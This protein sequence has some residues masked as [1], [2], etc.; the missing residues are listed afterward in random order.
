[1]CLD[2]SKFILKR[3]QMYSIKSINSIM[4]YY[5]QID[6]KISKV[7]LA[8]IIKT[9]QNAKSKNTKF[10]ILKQFFFF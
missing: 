4:I 5:E 3:K 6:F 9:S 7:I 1:M 8:I 2:I 10:C